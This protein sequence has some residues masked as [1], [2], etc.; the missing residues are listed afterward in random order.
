MIEEVRF[1]P[2]SPLEERVSCELVSEI[3][4]SLL[5]GKIQ[6]ISP[7]RG[8]AALGRHRKRARNQCLASQFPAHPNREFIAALQGIKSGDQGSFGRD[9]GIRFRPLFGIAPGDNPIVATDLERC[10]EGEKERCE[11]LEAVRSRSRARDRRCPCERR[12]G[13]ATNRSASSVDAT[14]SAFRTFTM[15]PWVVSRAPGC[16]ELTVDGG[17]R[18]R[19]S[20]PP[21]RSLSQQ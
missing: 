2:D 6:G 8:L 20:L 16:S 10:R 17:P 7:I 13:P 12:P 3:P 4:N 5:A 18:V 1:A 14:G 19:I 11:M 21:G 9:Q 15:A